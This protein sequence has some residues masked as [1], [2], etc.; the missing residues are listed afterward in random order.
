MVLQNIQNFFN[1][2]LQDTPD[3]GD[4][5]QRLQLATAALLIEVMRSDDVDHAEEQ[6]M[7]LSRLQAKFNLDH[8]RSQQLIALAEEEVRQATDYHQFTRLINEQFSQAQ[9]KHIIELMWDIAWADNQID[10]W[11]EH[12]IRRI[13]DLIYVSHE[14]FIAAKLAAMKSS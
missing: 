2:F 11:E 4:K 10:P 1:Q 7:L 12:L 5:E 14:D 9:K 6:Q 3:T 8:Q 13:A